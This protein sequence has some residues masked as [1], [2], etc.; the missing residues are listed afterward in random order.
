MPQNSSPD[1]LAACTLYASKYRLHASFEPG[2]SHFVPDTFLGRELLQTILDLFGK[3]PGKPCST[4]RDVGQHDVGLSFEPCKLLF[5]DLFLL[6]TSGCVKQCT[7]DDW[8]K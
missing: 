4:R 2:Q 6:G 3:M 8:D 5:H 1:A 7:D